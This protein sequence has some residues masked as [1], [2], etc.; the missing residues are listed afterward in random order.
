MSERHKGRR[1]LPCRTGLRL[2]AGAPCVALLADCP[3]HAQA[4]CRAPSGVVR[5]AQFV[6]VR[7]RRGEIQI[8]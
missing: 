3:V 1:A 5:F 2:K 8:A 6:C 4:R 7:L